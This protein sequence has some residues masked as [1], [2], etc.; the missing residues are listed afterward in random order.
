MTE[1]VPRHHQRKLMW[2]GQIIVMTF[3]SALF[4]EYLSAAQPALTTEQLR[5]LSDKVI[6]GKVTRVKRT[7]SLIEEIFGRTDYEISVKCE[8]LKNGEPEA[9]VYKAFAMN[10]LAPISPEAGPQGNT[11][12]KSEQRVRLYL[13]A[14]K[15]ES[16][17]AQY[18]VLHPNGTE[19][20][21]DSDKA[22]D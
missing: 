9:I 19:I 6:V 2:Y 1:D 15:T 4:A 5:K 20:L 11:I 13:K 16:G 3:V 8:S 18:R 21:K 10:Y 22:K 14:E 12:P 17:N 7:S